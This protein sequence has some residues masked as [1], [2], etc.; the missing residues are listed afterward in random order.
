MYEAGIIGHIID[1]SGDSL[2]L[3][4]PVLCAAAYTGL[5]RFKLRGSGRN[6]LAT[7]Y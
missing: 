1:Q 5:K 2:G 3:E 6:A 7:L 4:L